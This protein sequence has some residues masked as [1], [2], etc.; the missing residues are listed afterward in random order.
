MQIVNSVAIITGGASGLGEGT[1][2][3]FIARGGKVAG[4][5]LNRERGEVL[6][7]RH[8]GQAIFAAVDVSSE[9]SVRQGIPASLAAFGAIH[10]CVN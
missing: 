8:P 6:A 10:I 7:A 2:E 1:A 3:Y 4:F 5:D 9:S